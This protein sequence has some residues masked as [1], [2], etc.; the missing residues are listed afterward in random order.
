MN[1]MNLSDEIKVDD[2]ITIQDLKENNLVK[3]VA[4]CINLNISEKLKD[5]LSNKN[6]ED[7]VFLDEV[8]NNK[9]Y[10]VPA[11]EVV[12]LYNEASGKLKVWNIFLK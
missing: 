1:T 11:A 5:Y 7:L 6:P 4:D 2:I 10:I 12:R 3:T 8:Q 9:L